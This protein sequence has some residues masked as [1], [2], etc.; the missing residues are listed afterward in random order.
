MRRAPLSG[1]GD[2]LASSQLR[3]RH[4]NDFRSDVDR[5]TLHIL[6]DRAP[7][8]RLSTTDEQSQELAVR[9]MRSTMRHERTGFRRCHDPE[10]Q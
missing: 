6:K 4:V 3:Q 8:I 2:P 1:C 10:L 5:A 9:Y 7:S